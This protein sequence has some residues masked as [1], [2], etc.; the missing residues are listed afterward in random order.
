MTS[1][2]DMLLQRRCGGTGRTVARLGGTV[3]LLRPLGLIYRFA[4]EV[5]EV[6]FTWTNAYIADGNKSAHGFFLMAREVGVPAT[7]RVFGSPLTWQARPR[8]GG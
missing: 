7:V 3:P 4:R 8:S 1:F 5:A 6:G 2:K